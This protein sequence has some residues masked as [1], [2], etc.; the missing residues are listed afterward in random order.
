MKNKIIKFLKAVS[1]ENNLYIFGGITA[2]LNENTSIIYSLN[3]G[4]LSSKT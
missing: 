2:D 1:N 4:I 3:Y